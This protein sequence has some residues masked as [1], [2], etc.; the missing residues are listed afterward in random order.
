[1]SLNDRLEDFYEIRKIHFYD[2]YRQYHFMVYRMYASSEKVL[3]SERR[4]EK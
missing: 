2:Y 3:E 4:N 1:M